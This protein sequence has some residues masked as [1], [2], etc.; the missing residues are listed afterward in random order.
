MSLIKSLN[1]SVHTIYTV[2]QYH[3]P[4]HLRTGQVLLKQLHSTP[5]M[6]KPPPA[7]IN[8]IIFCL[9]GHFSWFIFL[10]FQP[11][12][13]KHLPG[14]LCNKIVPQIPLI[15][16]II[17]YPQ[18]SKHLLKIFQADWFSCYFRILHHF[19]NTLRS[20]QYIKLPTALAS[21]IYVIPAVPFTPD[22]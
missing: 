18:R 12:L 5:M 8:Q 14:G 2:R 9:P 15:R 10:P 4:L 16:P 21:I 19:I 20:R 6:H 1:I 13:S 3:T 22:G 17:K 11:H 7:S